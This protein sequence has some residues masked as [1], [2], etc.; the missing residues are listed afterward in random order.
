MFVRL[1]VVVATPA[2]DISLMFRAG[3]RRVGWRGWQMT[4]ESDARYYERR[5]EQELDLAAAAVDPAVKATHLNMA[6]QYATLRERS[7][8]PHAAASDGYCI[9]EVSATIDGAAVFNLER[10]MS[11]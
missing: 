11:E 6:A 5:G 3:R 10:G 8:L 2:R 9:E 7:V 1:D 4:I